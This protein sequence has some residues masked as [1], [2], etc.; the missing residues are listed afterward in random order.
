MQTK[1][2]AR[3]QT[4]TRTSIKKYEKNRTE[5]NRTELKTENGF[6]CSERNETKDSEEKQSDFTIKKKPLKRNMYVCAD[7]RFFF[8]FVSKKKT[9][10]KNWT[11]KKGNCRS[12]ASQNGR[13][14]LLLRLISA[15]KRY[16]LLLILNE[17]KIVQQ[18]SR[19]D[20]NSIVCHGPRSMV[21]TR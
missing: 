20:M 1:A 17:K 8:W 4:Q 11:S 16:T 12:G 3:T 18:N 15:A 5:Q 7:L 14:G 13:A 19:L 9:E 2:Q 6:S 10:K 21:Y